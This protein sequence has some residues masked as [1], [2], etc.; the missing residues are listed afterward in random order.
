MSL[1]TIKDYLSSKQSILIPTLSGVGLY[2]VLSR[3]MIQWT[4]NVINASSE[5]TLFISL[6]SGGINI[7]IISP[8]L[9]NFIQGRNLMDGITFDKNMLIDVSITSATTYGLMYLLSMLFTNISRSQLWFYASLCA[10]IIGSY[11]LKPIIRSSIGLDQE[12]KT[13]VSIQPVLPQPDPQ[14]NVMI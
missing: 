11:I 2:W 3:K 12:S 13:G 7:T 8:I 1:I 5:D 9:E 6:I 4:Q 10:S 14:P